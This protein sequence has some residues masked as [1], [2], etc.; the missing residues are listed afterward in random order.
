M[1]SR[2]LYPVVMA[3]GIGTRLWPYSRAA[4]P[5]QLLPIGGPRT[6]LQQ[7]VARL[8]S[9]AEAA[10]IFVVTNEEYV[11]EVRRQLPEVPAGNVVGE[12]AGLGTAPAVALGAALVRSRDPAGIVAC[13]PA[14]HVIA[15]DDGFRA[16]VDAAEM[17]ARAGHVA[18][19]GIPPSRPETGFGYIEVGEAVAGLTGVRHVAAFREKPDL[20]TAREYA[21]SGRHLWNAGLFIWS[22]EVILEEYRRHLPRL[23][24]Q[25]AAMSAAASGPDFHRRLRGIWAN[26][27]DRTTV[28]YGILEAS[29]RVVCVAASFT[30]TD[31]GSWDTVGEVVG[32]DEDGMSVVGR[33]LGVDSRNCVVFSAG[34]RLVATLGVR[35]L[36][37]VDTGDVVMVCPRDRAQEVKRLVNEWLRS[38][39]PGE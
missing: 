28:D 20:P 35:D 38:K 5:K 24:E 10:D 14:D 37:I 34:D 33:H 23:A 6:L 13:V 18:V 21:S 30:W 12:P 16:T 25:M 11:A 29:D 19:I 22:V 36:V 31:L 3:G 9:V 1:T 8:D 32:L 4:R 27:T 17:A 7:T 2:T 39:S 15:P 26:I